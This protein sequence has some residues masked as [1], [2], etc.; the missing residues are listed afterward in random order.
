M[1]DCICPYI[2]YILNS[3][4]DSYKEENP[5]LDEEFIFDIYPLGSFYI[6]NIDDVCKTT[7]YII[8]NY[9][10]IKVLR[11]TL[12]K[13]RIIVK[14]ANRILP[15]CPNYNDF[16]DG[17]VL[18]SIIRSFLN[19]R[20]LCHESLKTHFVFFQYLSST[21]D[22]FRKIQKNSIHE[23]DINFNDLFTVVWNTLITLNSLTKK[24]STDYL[25]CTNISI[26]TIIEHC[27]F[28]FRNSNKTYHPLIELQEYS[29]LIDI[30]NL[31]NTNENHR[32]IEYELDK[33]ID[34]LIHQKSI[35]EEMYFKCLLIITHYYA[36]YENL[37]R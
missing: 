31:P 16:I 26:N 21:F 33:R 6:S 17:K 15:L 12:L 8:N 23:S 10:S 32:K 7:N 27:N 28:I 22:Y 11:N 5:E 18:F 13:Y 20:I 3:I 4:D 2:K 1:T 9:F 30:N 14:N 29:P 25:D 37:I 24:G 36:K 35:L 19:N 34:C